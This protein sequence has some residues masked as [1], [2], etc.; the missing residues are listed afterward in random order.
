MLKPILAAA[1]LAATLTPALAGPNDLK[2]IGDQCASQLKLAPTVCNC[3]VQKASTDLNNNQ[4]A[5]MAAQVTHNTQEIG[6]IQGML[7]VQEAAA[8]GQFMSTVVGACG[9]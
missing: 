3:M 6:R 4:Q 9:G 5:F 1:L 8:T 7:T 2:I